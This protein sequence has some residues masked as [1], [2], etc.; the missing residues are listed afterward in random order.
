MERNIK[1]K[2]ILMHFLF[3]R[4]TSTADLVECFRMSLVNSF[5]K[6]NSS[7]EM[8]GIQPYISIS[9]FNREYTSLIEARPIEE[10]KPEEL[11]W[12]TLGCT[13][14]GNALLHAVAE[15]EKIYK[16]WKMDGY[17]PLHPYYMLVTDGCPD[18]GEGATE[19]QQKKVMDNFYEAAKII[20][21]GETHVRSNGK[22]IPDHTF[23]AV[24]ISGGKHSANIELLK[25]LTTHP[26]HVI[27][28]DA[29]Y[30]DDENSKAYKEI[31]KT[32]EDLIE[33]TTKLA[34]TPLDYQFD[35]VFGF[36]ELF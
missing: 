24:G 29:S 28:I 25:E 17:E 11:N 36:D 23:V 33:K 2:I 5:K 20:K 15:G 32:F 26:S 31:E 27:E 10:I 30:A 6:I 18:A 19:E 14:I 7:E 13:D 3:D 12:Q 35:D 16:Q 9:L 1:K 8:V 21:A 4:S 22:I 34:V